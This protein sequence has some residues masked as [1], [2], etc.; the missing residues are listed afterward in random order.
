MKKI[1]ILPI[2]LIFILS[3][4]SCQKE[5]A[6][7]QEK[8]NSVSVVSH[9][10]MDEIY[11]MHIDNGVDCDCENNILVFRDWE[12]F[13]AT[14][15]LLEDLRDQH[16]TA[17]VENSDP[18]MTDLEFEAYA[19]ALGFHEEQ[20]YLDFEATYQFASLRKKLYDEETAW[21][22]SLRQHE[23]WNLD[24]DPDNHFTFYEERVLLNEQAEVIV[25][26]S[27]GNNVIYKFYEG[28][29]VTITDN[30]YD[31]LQAFNPFN[32][33]DPSDPVPPTN[34]PVG[35]PVAYNPY[36]PCEGESG[37]NDSPLE[38]PWSNFPA[39]SPE[40]CDTGGPPEPTFCEFSN[41]VRDS[42]G[43]GSDT[44]IKTVDKFRFYAP[45]L[46]NPKVKAKTTY[47]RW[48]NAPWPLTG[49][50]WV[51]GKTTISAGITS[52]EKLDC[53]GMP[54]FAETMVTK[55]RSKVKD[56]WTWKGTY[57]DVPGPK[58]RNNMLYGT[59]KRRSDV[60]KVIDF[61]DGDVQ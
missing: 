4:T 53:S 20:P 26:D 35:T 54:Y 7:F 45:P 36:L 43:T 42:F 28:G 44:K 19:D 12:T 29:Y 25:K 59:H 27:T 10:E 14:V 30:R 24:L 51:R 50:A 48:K 47:Y 58:V 16:I 13:R 21:L 18:T 3:F 46:G 2:A 23:E 40:P 32:P 49:G 39:F 5:P 9:G 15:E 57:Y 37:L 31:L 34:P 11:A 56:K 33:V 22:K 61:Y 6:D 17:F 38:N 60:T 52:E 8:T 55:K 1:T 41:D